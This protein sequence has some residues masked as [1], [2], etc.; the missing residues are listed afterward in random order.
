MIN[1]I[2]GFFCSFFLHAFLFSF[3]FNI[4]FNDYSEEKIVQLPVN[5]IFEE[6]IEPVPKKSSSKNVKTTS[7]SLSEDAK[8]KN[9]FESDVNSFFSNLER[10]RDRVEQI[11][12]QSEVLKIAAKIRAE[13]EFLW[14]KPKNL[15][16]D[17]FVKVLI[18]I[19]PSGE[20][21]NYEILNKSG[22]EVFDRS[23]RIALDRISSFDFIKNISRNDF[24]KN[25]REFN[26]Q[27]SSN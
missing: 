7:S 15:P 1:L 18:S 14:Q 24:E 9:D 4:N 26:L 3:F 17:L 11:S 8:S 5:L 16:E 27:F 20:V 13:Y 10:D 19:A 2:A 23:I 6:K 25:F 12:T 21:V 22:N